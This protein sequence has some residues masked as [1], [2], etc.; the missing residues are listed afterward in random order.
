[1][2]STSQR[3]TGASHPGQRHVKSR[4]RT[5]SAV[6]AE[7]RYPGSACPV[8]KF[9]GLNVAELA[10]SRTDSAGRIPNEDRYPGWLLLPSIVACS[11]S[12]WLTAAFAAARCAGSDKSHACISGIVYKV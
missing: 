6:A 10:S 1:M 4:H 2:W 7:G 5:K 8:G 3:S 9:T 12:T 11:A